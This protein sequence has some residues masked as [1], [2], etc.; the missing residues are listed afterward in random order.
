MD[1]PASIEAMKATARPSGE[2]ANW[3]EGT[4]ELDPPEK[5]VPL[6]G[7]MANRTGS[8][9]G[10]F[11][12]FDTT[13]P[14]IVP[15]TSAAAVIASHHGRRCGT[16]AAGEGCSISQFSATLRSRAV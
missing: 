10:C 1:R 13:Q 16:R 4:D 12:K 7:L 14:T 3:G 6:G 11:R 2:I 15:L 5:M 9:T 8:V